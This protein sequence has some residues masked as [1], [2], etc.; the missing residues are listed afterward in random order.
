M[1]HCQSE[2]LLK[3]LVFKDC[4][5]MLM[6]MAGS[7]SCGGRAFQDNGLDEENASEPNVENK[8]T[9]AAI[10]IPDVIF[11]FRSCQFIKLYTSSLKTITEYDGGWGRRDEG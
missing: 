3:R 6:E 2:L 11:I 8:Q 10:A 4:L 7:R 5:K 9:N 1:T